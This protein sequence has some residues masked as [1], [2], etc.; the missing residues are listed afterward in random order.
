MEGLGFS[1]YWFIFLFVL[2][3][4]LLVEHFYGEGQYKALSWPIPL[5]ILLGAIP[6]TLV[7]MMLNNKPA[8]V[9]IDPETNEKVELKR[10]HS[11]FWIPMQYWGVILVVLSVLIYLR[12]IGFSF[13]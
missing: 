4:E 8:R 10:E 6:T 5:A 2:P 7:G 1:D 12:N 3:I 11:L 13:N 9:L